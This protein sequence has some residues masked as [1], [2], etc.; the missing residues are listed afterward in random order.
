MK[1]GA[2][3][4]LSI[5]ALILVLTGVLF[6]AVFCL[7]T[8]KVV[9]LGET[10]VTISKEDI[11]SAAGFKKGESIFLLDK[12][13]AISNIEAKHAEIKVVQIKTTSVTEIEI[14]IRARHKMFYTTFGENYFILDEDLKVLDIIS[15]EAWA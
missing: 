10:P 2:V 15:S 4:T 14:R 11:V 3:I 8:Q 1:K 7:R 9:V 13:K 12:E 5:V 6:G